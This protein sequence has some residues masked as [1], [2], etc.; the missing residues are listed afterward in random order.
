M[1]QHP[2]PDSRKRAGQ[3]RRAAV[4]IAL[5]LVVL[6]HLLA[7]EWLKSELQ[8][9][10]P[11]DEADEPPV[12]VTLQ[13]PPPPAVAPPPPSPPPAKPLPPPDTAQPYA[14]V[15]LAETPPPAPAPPPA[16]EAPPVAEAAPADST[17]ITS[18]A[19]PAEPSPEPPSPPA[20]V[21]STPP[22]FERALPPPADL[23]YSVVVI[24]GGTRTM[25]S[26]S[27]SW[28]HDGRRY[29]LVTELSK[30]LLPL[31]KFRSDGT[32]GQLGIEPDLYA[33][34]R[35]G[36]SETNTHFRKEQQL[37]SFSASTA[38]V[39]AK[40]GE[41]DQSS[42]AWQLASLG[43]GDPGKFEA[44]LT[45]EMTV[46]SKKAADVWRLYVNGRENIVLPDGS[47]SAWRISAVP[48]PNS[49]EKQMELWLAPERDW[50][51]VRL[52][53]VDKNGNSIELMLTKISARK[54]GP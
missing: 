44:G 7:I 49:F 17:A 5:L 52:T 14:A 26:G 13:T 12:S 1:P 33:E 54:E 50:Y 20:P 43:R 40:G 18:A 11:D 29:T 34:K 28:R 47:V 3:R 32:I 30:F 4:V 15:P 10:A 16:P 51:P 53:H 24:N 19:P 22:L 38:T 39:P 6:A 42:W 8:L 46:A 41:Q 25:G 21:A 35:L 37:I 9:I 36:R 2:V 48:G 31:A 45:L 23:N 27:V